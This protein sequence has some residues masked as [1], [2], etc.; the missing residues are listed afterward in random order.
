M[1]LSFFVLYAYAFYFGGVLRWNEVESSPGVLYSG[2]KLIGV[3]FCVVFG[4]MMLGGAGPHLNAIGEG[5]VAGRIAFETIDQ[6]PGIK[7]NEK[8][9]FE[10]NN[11]TGEI[12]FSNV[13]FT[14]PSRPEVQVLK[15]FSEVFEA[16]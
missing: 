11:I 2:G 5:R 6:I 10:V 4:A 8:G 9:S 13:N 1:F 3:L 16:G 14:Y 15:D 12:R 7:V